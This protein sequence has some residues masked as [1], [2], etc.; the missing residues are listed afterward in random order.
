VLGAA[1]CRFFD[2]AIANA[3]TG[4]G[5]EILH[6][7]RDAFQ[8]AGVAVLYG[9][10][11]SVFVQ[12]G[13]GGGDARMAEAERLRDRV[14]D[15]IG[16]YIRASYRVASHL[17][18]ELECIYDRFFMPRVRSGRSG[19][20]KRYAGWR[21]GQLELVGLE[22]V[23]RDWPAVARRLQRGLLERAFSDAPTLPFV[24]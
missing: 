1:S 24:R 20:K 12:L 18:P 10:T 23:R 7:T 14:Q 9:D 5:Q 13:A 4:F 19:S 2:P 22:S 17:E 15:E 21:S 6:R 11:D 8:A 3:I 16:A